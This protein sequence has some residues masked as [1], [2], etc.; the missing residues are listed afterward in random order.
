MTNKHT[1]AQATERNLAVTCELP[2][3]KDGDNLLVD[4]RLLHQQLG[5]KRQFANWI[6]DQ[7]ADYGFEE[8]KDYLTNLLSKKGSGGHNAK[9]YHLTL[10]TAKEIAMVSKTEAGRN[11]RRYF[12]EK[13]KEL[14]NLRLYGQKVNLSE[15][16]RNVS[17]RRINGYTMYPLRKVRQLLGYST[18]SSTSGLKQRFVGL[19][20]EIDNVCYAAE[21]VVQVL[22]AR[23]T[24]RAKTAEALAASP[25]LPMGFGDASQLNLFS[26]G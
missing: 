8:N 26:N 24:A 11:I 4:A 9:E 10:D 21:Q 20:I 3:I 13:E 6:K 23:S 1:K 7:L 25:V 15:L 17:T 19:L 2:F 5:S 22:V 18:K 14:R 16:K 12:I